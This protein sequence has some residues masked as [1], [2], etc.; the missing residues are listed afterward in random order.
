MCGIGVTSS[1]LV[2]LS[3]QAFSART[4]D[5]RPGPG[6]LH[7]DFDRAARRVPARPRRPSRPRPARRTACSCASRGS[8]QPP[9]VAQDERVA[10][11]VGDRD[12]RVVERRVHV[13]D[14]VRTWRLT[15]LRALRAARRLRAP[16]S[17]PRAS[18]AR[19]R[20][21][22]RLAS[23]FARS[24]GYA[25]ARSSD[26]ARRRV[27]LD[28]RACADPCAC[29]HW[30]ACADRA[31]AGPCGDGCRGTQPRSIRRLMLIETLAA[32]V[33]FDREAARSASAAR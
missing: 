30:C 8:P 23:G 29:A 12:D 25:F 31:S 32:Q 27:R 26:L 10:L 3:P 1:M 33:A 9:E 4:A 21:C 20:R 18:C 24:V 16:L 17:P 28:R 14:R 2:T 13:R 5:S 6:P 11:A 22:I 7:A 19:R 15:F